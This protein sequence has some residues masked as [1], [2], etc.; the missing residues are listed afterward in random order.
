MARLMML[1]N[2]ARRNSGLSGIFFVSCPPDFLPD[3]QAG[4]KIQLFFPGGLPARGKSDTAQRVRSL[5]GG[6]MEY[7]F[8]YMTAPDRE[9]AERIARVI[10]EERL[11]AC[12]NILNPILSLYWWRGRLEE[13]KEAVCVF[14][15][16]GEAFAALEARVRELHPYETPC[17]VALPI[18]IGSAPFL[19]WLEEETKPLPGQGKPYNVSFQ[20]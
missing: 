9:T 1:V 5:H 10:V 17:V 12:A 2:A 20:E 19:R 6:K 4:G 14:K 8:V 18:A 11:A 7:L 3:R 15:T 16:T 13:T